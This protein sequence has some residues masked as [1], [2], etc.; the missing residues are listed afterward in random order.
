ME[1]TSSLPPVPSHPM[2]ER[3][4]RME[5]TISAVFSKM[6]SLV[7]G[8]PGVMAAA[9]KKGG[10]GAPRGGATPRCGKC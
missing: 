8:L 7:S 6:A 5:D 4:D 3:L 2:D 9:I 1:G 10:G